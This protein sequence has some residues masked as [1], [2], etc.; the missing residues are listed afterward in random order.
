MFFLTAS[1]GA[2]VTVYWSEPKR[3]GQSDVFIFRL[4]DK[5]KLKNYV[6][7][8]MRLLNPVL[9]FYNGG[10]PKNVGVFKFHCLATNDR[11]DDVK[12]TRK[13]Y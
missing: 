1:Y 3:Q 8:A 6:E 13:P 9:G 10:A 4:D 2:D 5:K 12:G 11:L 7:K